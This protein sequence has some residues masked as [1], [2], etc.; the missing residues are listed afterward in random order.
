MSLPT[1]SG[2]T[3]RTPGSDSTVSVLV[4]RPIHDAHLARLRRVCW[5]RPTTDRKLGLEFRSDDCGRHV[6]VR[7]N[8]LTE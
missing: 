8:L 7:P 4:S 3:T 1:I 2:V 5:R 6:L